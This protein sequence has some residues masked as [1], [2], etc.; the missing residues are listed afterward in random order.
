MRCVAPFVLVFA[1]LFLQQRERKIYVYAIRAEKVAKEKAAVDPRIA[2]LK[3]TLT[4]LGNDFNRYELIS[5]DR[6]DIREGEKARVVVDAR[7]R[8]DCKV[9]RVLEGKVG[10]RLR[11]VHKEQEE[12]KVLLDTRYLLKEKPLVVVGVRLKRGRL[13]VVLTI[14]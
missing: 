7:L 9:E 11:I 5:S 13:V 2:D 8:I 6:M 10:V 1:V 14:R 4:A 3:K 12:E